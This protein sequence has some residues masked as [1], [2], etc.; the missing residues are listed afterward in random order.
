MTT[1]PPG[2]FQYARDTGQFR[3][4]QFCARCNRMVSKWHAHWT[5]PGK[6]ILI[7]PLGWGK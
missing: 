6:P 2:T 3:P 5:E 7:M 1:F 4:V